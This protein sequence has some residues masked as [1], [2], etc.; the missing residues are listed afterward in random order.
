MLSCSV[1]LL[2]YIVSFLSSSA[3]TSGATLGSCP[4]EMSSTA[5]MPLRVERRRLINFLLKSSWHLVTHTQMIKV[6]SG[7]REKEV[8]FY[9]NP[10]LNTSTQIS[11]THR[12]S[13]DQ[14]KLR[15]ER[16]WIEIMKL[17]SSVDKKLIKTVTIKLTRQVGLWFNDTELVKWTPS[18][19]PW[20]YD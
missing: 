12:W 15:L 14:S 17:P 11:V 10:S 3:V 4:D 1:F 2:Q 7:A 18:Q 20:S 5:V 6:D 19:Q 8:K 16:E 9:Q 13:N